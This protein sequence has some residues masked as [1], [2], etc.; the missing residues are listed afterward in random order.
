MRNDI[1]EIAKNLTELRRVGAEYRGRCPLHAEKTASF[2]VNPERGVFHCFGCGAGGG[3]RELARLAGMELPQMGKSKK[4]TTQKRKVCYLGKSLAALKAELFPG[5]TEIYEYR[6]SN[7]V[8]RALKARRGNGKGKEFRVATPVGATEFWQD[9][10]E[11]NSMIYFAEHLPEYTGSVLLVEGERVATRL[12]NH[13]VPVLGL[14]GAN[15]KPNLRALK[16]RHCVVWPDYDRGGVGLA[17]AIW[18]QI[19]HCDIIDL[20]VVAEA[21]STTK[22]DGKLKGCDALDLQM[23][24]V[25]SILD[26][27]NIKR[28]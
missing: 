18:T 5:F 19:E 28:R 15:A 23:S 3:A 9:G 4:M 12:Y 25:W 13:G 17:W 10:G 11:I 6:D 14:P 2:Y 26:K 21:L 22:A 20:S 7:R 27:Y 8:L 16:N 24:A 1:Y